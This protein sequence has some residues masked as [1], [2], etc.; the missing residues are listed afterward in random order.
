MASMTQE[1]FERFKDQFVDSLDPEA[2][3]RAALALIGGTV[4]GDEEE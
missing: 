2:S 1:E 4:E 3:A